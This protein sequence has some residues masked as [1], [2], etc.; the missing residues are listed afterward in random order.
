[1]AKKI[2]VLNRDT[3]RPITLRFAL[4]ADVPVARQS[5]YADV[6]F[7]SA[8]RDA[9]PAEMTALRSGAVVERVDQIVLPAGTSLAQIRAALITAFTRYQN[10]VTN[11]NAFDFYGTSWDGTAWTA[12]GVS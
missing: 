12:G 2:I 6:S 1:M 8:Y 5:F 3:E 7:V 4:W 10:S 9:T 11:D